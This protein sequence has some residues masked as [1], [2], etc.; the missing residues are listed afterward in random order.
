MTSLLTHHR[1]TVE[2]YQKL[3]D[4]LPPESR[5]ELIDGEVVEMSPIG[6]KHLWTVERLGE[7]LRDA[8]G[9][10]AVVIMEKPV[11]LTASSVPQPDL[12]VL[13]PSPG[14]RQRLPETVDVL[15]LMGVSDATL[16]K[17]LGIKAPLYG[18]CGIAELWIVDLDHNV[19]EQ[20]TQPLTGRYTHLRS[21]RRGET[22][23]GATLPRLSLAVDSILPEPAESAI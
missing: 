5:V 6:W 11:V 1:F 16:A 10:T 9:T 22:I 18:Q 19:I 13:R 12:A 8:L 7:L 2:E 4:I 15:V 3:A 23:T 21:Y 17:G 20:H 14:L